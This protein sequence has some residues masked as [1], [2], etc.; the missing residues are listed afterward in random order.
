[1]SEIEPVTPVA[2]AENLDP[3]KVELGRRLFGDVRLSRDGT[4]S[5][6]SC[7][8]LEQGGDDGLARAVGA[9]G[10]ALD[11]NTPSVFNAARNFRLNWRGNFRSLEEQNEAVLTDPRLMNARW[12]DVLPKLRADRG[13]AAEF[14]RI[15]GSV[16]SREGVLDVLATYQR[17]LV[18]PNSRFD[19]RLNGEAAAITLDE[20]QG[21]QL[22]K[23]YGCVACHQGENFGGNLFQRFGIFAQAFGFGNGEVPTDADLGRYSITGRDE[24]RFVFRVPSLRNVAVTAPY[25]H[26]GRVATLDKAVDVM[27]RKQLGREIPRQDV[28]LI[29]KF[30]ETLTGEHP[31]GPQPQPLNFGLP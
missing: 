1:M 28:T 11:F 9:D 27:A 15:Y 13:Y 25:F 29:V 14:Y 23:T 7:H 31:D 17:S 16:P 10:K 18:T 12:Q 4:R 3:R 6:A 26:D 2:S 21:Y 5:C 22:F 20:E 19:R 24:D 30:L 8:I